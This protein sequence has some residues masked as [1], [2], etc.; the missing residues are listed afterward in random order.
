MTADPTVGHC[1]LGHAR[2]GSGRGEGPMGLGS[3][4]S[5]SYASIHCISVSIP[6]C[7][8]A[9]Q[10]YFSQIL[11]ESQVQRPESHTLF[12]HLTGFYHA[13]QAGLQPV[14]TL[15]HQLKGC[16]SQTCLVFAAM[17][18]TG[19]GCWVAGSQARDTRSL[20]GSWG[21]RCGGYRMAVWGK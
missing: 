5:S 4:G 19:P 20:S 12:C 9:N 6:R 1:G 3:L 7:Y 10:S 16:T 2:C 14:V 15:L 8:M 13:A 18:L 21:L 11:P 17:K